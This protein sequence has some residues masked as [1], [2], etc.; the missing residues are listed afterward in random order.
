M[1]NLLAALLGL[2]EGLT[3]FLPVSSTAHLLI[4]EKL[5]RFSDPG[6]N[7]TVMIQLG[8]IL[9]VVVLYFRRLWQAVID[10]PGKA[11]AR[12]FALS[13]II[14]FLPAAVIGV[15]IH[16]LIGEMFENLTIIC[17]A[18]IVGGLA[19]WLVDK[20]AP[21]PEYHDSMQLNFRTALL[22]GLFQCL[23]MIPGMSRSGST[24]IGGMLSRVDKK[25]GAEFSFFLAIPTMLGA[26]VLELVTKRHELTASSHVGMGLI[27]IGFVVA[28]FVALLVVRWFVGLVGRTG[29][30]PFGWYRIAVGAV[31]LVAVV[32]V[33]L[34]GYPFFHGRAGADGTFAEVPSY[35]RQAGAWLDRHADGKTSV[36]LP[37]S[38]FG[39]FT[40]GR[41]LDDPLVSSTDQPIAV[42]D[43]VPLGSNGATRL[44]DGLE[45]QLQD[46]RFEAGT[47]NIADAVGL[48][49][50]ID[51]VTRLGIENIGAYEHQLLA[52]A[53]R[54]I[55]DVPGVRLIG[56]AKDKASVLSFTLKGYE[57][58]EVG[59]ALNKEGIAVRSGHHCAQPILRRFGVEGTVRP[60][61]AFY[62]TCAEVDLLINTLHRLSSAKRR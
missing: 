51:Y 20:F 52:Y 44:L 16:K 9:A 58:E 29:F 4:A 1:H 31:A 55:K 18:L 38:P 11:E 28:F 40:W 61:L 43:I 45:A 10:L 53:T 14:A 19:L 7:F 3:E 26:T 35:W 6:G 32:A 33:S 23:A 47:G 62:N 42:R 39:E 15:I 57:T 25:A 60:S 36:V 50:A 34:G 27:A 24:L 2:I 54:L 56:T 41:P 8:A 5:L 37:A 59:A 46:G 48:G 49:A 22:I 13:V 30:S 21:K 12:R 17:V